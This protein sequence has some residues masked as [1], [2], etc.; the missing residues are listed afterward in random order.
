MLPRQ[1]QIVLFSATFPDKV[2]GFAQ[3]FAPQSNELR[4]K[5]EELTVEG[6]KQFY[7]DCPGVHAKYDVLVKLYGLMTIGSSIIFVKVEYFVSSSEMLL[8]FQKRRDTAA[9]IER[10]MT[11]EGHKVVS[12][13]GAYEGSQRDTIIDAFRDF[14][15]KVLI[16][17]NVLARGIDVQTVNLVINY[18]S[19]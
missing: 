11:E 8:T 13:T 14:K 18:V 7:M 19:N 4:L 12:L 16:T 10:R 1:I 2:V 3:K 15:A 6:I 9:E 17:T 5:T